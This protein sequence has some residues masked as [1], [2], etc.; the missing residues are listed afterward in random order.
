[1]ISFLYR[2]CIENRREKV[3]FFESDKKTHNI[4]QNEKSAKYRTF[5]TIIRTTENTGLK[6]ATLKI[7]GRW[8][9]Q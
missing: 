4:L 9:C 7:R 1:M 8:Q 3:P 2:R 5:V 6:L